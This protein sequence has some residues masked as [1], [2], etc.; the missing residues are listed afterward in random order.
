[1]LLF[2]IGIDLP[3]AIIISF[4]IFLIGSLSF[5]ISR[6][7]WRKLLKDQS[8]IF[9]HRLAVI[10][11]FVLTPCLCVGLFLLIV[12]IV[13][14]TTQISDEEVAEIH[15][16]ILEEDLPE[17]LVIGM[18][19][20]DVINRFGETDTTKSVWTYDLSLPRAKEKYILEVQFENGKLIRYGRTRDL[21]KT[22]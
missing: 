22:P 17:D 18:S 1:M 16:R 20:S 12:S 21:K 8:K 7:A 9:V 6:F 5:K 13:E 15:Y 14:Q 19:K 4:L 3:T 10:S 11:A 2:L